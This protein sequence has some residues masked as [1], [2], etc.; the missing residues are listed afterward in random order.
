MRGISALL[1]YDLRQDSGNTV[2][3]KKSYKTV[4]NGYKIVTVL[5][6]LL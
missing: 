2:V 3:G 5:G 6:F 4:T 1:Q